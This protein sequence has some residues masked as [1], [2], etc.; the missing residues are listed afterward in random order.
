MR[1][2]LLV[3]ALTL[4]AAAPAQAAL[5]F[6]PSVGY[7][8]GGKPP[9]WVATGDLNLD[10]HQDVAAALGNAPGQVDVLLGD[11]TGTLT[12]APGAPYAAAHLMED[13]AVGDLTRDG[14]P[15]IVTLEEN[16]IV[17]R[18]GDGSGGYATIVNGPEIIFSPDHLV[19]GNFNGDA[20]LDVAVN[21]AVQNVVTY[22]TNDG[23]GVLTADT[24]TF[25]AVVSIGGLA[26]ADVNGDGFDDLLASGT[27]NGNVFRS[28]NDGAGD[29]GAPTAIPTGL[30]TVGEVQ[31]GDVDGDTDPDIVA[32]G[33]GSMA[34][35][36]NLGAGA[37][38]TPVPTAA[39]PFNFD[40]VDLTTDRV[41]DLVAGD[42][43]VL[44]GAPAGT[45]AAGTGPVS[46]SNTAVA[47]MNED[48][49][50]DLIGGG[51]SFA[52]QVR[53]NSSTPVRNVDSTPL[54]FGELGVGRLSEP[55]TV[56]MS[57]TGHAA[58]RVSSVVATSA[59]FVIS[60]QS[61][62]PRDIIVGLGCSVQVRFSPASPGDKDAELV[63]TDNAGAAATIDLTGK[64]VAEPVGPTGPTGNQGPVG[65]PGPQGPQGPAGPSGPAGGDG[66]PGAAGVD[67]VRGPDGSGRA[68]RPDRAGGTGGRWWPRGR[69]RGRRA[70]PDRWTP[71]P[72]TCSRA[73]ASRRRS[74]PRPVSQR[75][76]RAA[77]T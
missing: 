52:V 25:P 24:R 56:F 64:G 70:R 7:P 15:D 53:L 4:S 19:L 14:V 67:G 65:N 37:F 1:R 31:V 59:D 68:V 23:D 39:S 41:L 21:A 72:R 34:F 17:V 33:G 20:A 54:V 5:T 13:I 12:R 43:S 36:P 61:C 22:L 27:G 63:I 47:D 49:R 60:S 16:R 45:F 8:T 62:A 44:L 58:L 71:R 51:P 26:A 10:G 30:S 46:A 6:A 76:A 48:G 29:F 73:S 40:L 74:S 35:L 77:A 9:H 18:V 66:A 11:G 75:A 50:P 2:A 69:R 55:K 32:R 3:I 57:N 42:G 38:G 28:L